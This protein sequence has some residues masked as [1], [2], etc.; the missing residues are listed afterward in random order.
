LRSKTCRQLF[1][2]PFGATTGKQTLARTHAWLLG[3]HPDAGH[4]GYPVLDDAG[5]VIG[6]PTRRDLL[7]AGRGGDV[8]LGSL[9]TRP[10]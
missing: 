4:R 2:R 5:H 8:T 6:L 3:G 9:V 10:R 1:G 7:G